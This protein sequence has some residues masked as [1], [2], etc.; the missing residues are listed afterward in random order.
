[1]VKSYPL[2]SIR[3][4]L[5]KMGCAQWMLNTGLRMAEGVPDSTRASEEFNFMV[6]TE[7]EW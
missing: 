3:F 1:M 5:F 4:L 6:L 2:M 7:G